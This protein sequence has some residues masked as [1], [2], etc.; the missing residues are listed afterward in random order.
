[1]QGPRKGSM[2]RTISALLLLA[3]CY[4]FFAL[5]APVEL[6]ARDAKIKSVGSEYNATSPLGTNLTSIV[7]WSPEW[8]FSD[9]FKQSRTW[10]SSTPDVWDDGRKLDLDENGWVKSLLPGQQ[11]RTLMFWWDGD[12][13][14]PAGKYQVLYDG[15]GKITSFTQR[16]LS[17]EPGKLTMGVAP[18]NGGI[19]LTIEETNPN[20]YI[21]NIRVIGPET[22]CADAACTS[23]SRFS[24]E[25][26]DSIRS[27][28]VLR[29]MDWMATNGSKVSSFDNRPKVSDARYSEKGV[30]VEI[31][32]ELANTLKADPWFTMPHLADDDYI[33]KFATY[34]RDH[35]DADR[36]VY[37]EHSN[38][39]WNGMFDQ[40]HYA[41]EQGRKQNLA[42]AD[43]EAQLNYHSRRSVQIFKIW[44]KVFAGTSRFVRVMGSQVANAWVSEVLLKYEDA[45]RSTDAL[46]IAPYFGGYLGDT[47]QEAR[48]QEM[49]ADDVIAELRERQFPEVKQWLTQQKEVADEF[50]VDLIAYEGGQHLVGVGN[51]VNNERISNLFTAV[52]R[53]PAMKDIYLQYLDL[54]KRAGGGMFVNFANTATVSKWGN[55]GAREYLSQ[56]LEQAPKA[57]ALQTFI[58]THPAE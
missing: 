16:I 12:K 31:M 1:M 20:N 57:D 15:E 56:P 44:E 7:D 14:Y 37:V 32:V 52:N 41:L 38:E 22:E 46:A 4:L 17:S 29:F 39:V 45:Y 27:F 8:A 18:K 19:A 10:I 49:T 43:F 33:E 21:R 13:H 40:A 9:A 53:H 5:S 55:W 42:S 6:A 2:Y 11:A 48:V 47:E 28:R 3:A 25:F 24:K 54:W 23:A 36:L 26:L 58:Q 34:V 35:L 51:V 30:P 50:G